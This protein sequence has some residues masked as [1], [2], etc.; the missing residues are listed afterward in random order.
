[1]ETLTRKPHS[2]GGKVEGVIGSRW[3]DDDAVDCGDDTDKGDD[4]A[5]DLSNLP[6]FDFLS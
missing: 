2:L 5:P 1:M 4:P 6:T 3:C